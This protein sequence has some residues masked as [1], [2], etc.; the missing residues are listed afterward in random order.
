MMTD[1]LVITANSLLDNLFAAELVGRLK[2]G[3]EIKHLEIGYIGVV[4]V[5]DRPTEKAYT[6]LSEGTELNP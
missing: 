5:L 1:P 2:Q 6:P 4:C 3:Y